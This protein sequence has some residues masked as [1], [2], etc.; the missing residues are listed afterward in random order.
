MDNHLGYGKSEPVENPAG[1]T[2]NGKSKSK[3]TLKGTHRRSAR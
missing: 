1:N 2:G 3:K